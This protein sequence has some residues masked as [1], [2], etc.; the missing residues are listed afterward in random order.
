MTLMPTEI[1]QISQEGDILQYISY[2]TQLL[3]AL[4]L[5]F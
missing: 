1:L 5:V 4:T 3:L 2:K